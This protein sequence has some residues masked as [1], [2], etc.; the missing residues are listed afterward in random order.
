MSDEAQKTLFIMAALAI[1]NVKGV[2]AAVKY[3][4]LTAGW[5]VP[6]ALDMLDQYDGYRNQVFAGTLG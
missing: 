5:T 6:E 3:L 4:N 1:Y 2:S